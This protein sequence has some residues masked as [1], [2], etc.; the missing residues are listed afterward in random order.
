MSL[1]FLLVSRDTSP[2]ILCGMG[3]ELAVHLCQPL[4][5]LCRD[6]EISTAA[7]SAAGHEAASH[8]HAHLP[9]NQLIRQVGRHCLPHVF[10]VPKEPV[11]PFA[12]TLR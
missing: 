8:Q 10:V 4:Y 3:G 12:G 7:A 11:V 6:L 1:F 2:S 5:A 9:N